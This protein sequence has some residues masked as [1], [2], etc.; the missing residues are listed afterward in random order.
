MP[1][2][3][4]CNVILVEDGI[5]FESQDSHPKA[6]FTL[7]ND[8]KLF[9]HRKSRKI[10]V[11][12]D[13]IVQNQ[14]SFYTRK[15]HIKIHKNGN[16]DFEIPQNTLGLEVNI[17]IKTEK[18]CCNKLVEF[19]PENCRNDFLATRTE[20]RMMFKHCN[21]MAIDTSGLDHTPVKPG[22]NRVFGHQL[23]PCR[24]AR[25][26]AIVHIA[27][28]EAI[29][30]I[31]GGYQSLLNLPPVSSSA[32]V[33]AAMCQA[34]HDTLVPLF[35]SH[36]PRLDSI[37]AAD[38]AQIPN[39]SS[40]SNGINAG[41]AAASAILANRT[42]DGSNHAEPVYGVDYIPSGAPGEWEQD[43]ISQI[44]VALGALWSQVTPFVIPSA[45]AYRCPVPPA[46]NSVEYMMAFNDA[47]AMGG[48]G[49]TTPTIRSDQ[50][51]QMGIFWAYDGTPSLCAPPRLYNQLCMQI[52][53]DNGLDT[54]ELMY[55][56]T[57]L[58]VGMADVG[59]AS[60]ES[61]YFYKLWRPVTGIRRAAE[62]GNPG[63]IADP[64]WTPMGAPASNKNTV[65]FTPPFPTYPSGHAS[66]GGCVF[67]L[68]RKFLPDNTSF[69]FVSDELNGETKDNQGN[70][71]PLI[72]RS[73]TSFSQAEEENGK[74]RIP[75]GIH[76]NQ[77]KTSGIIIGNQIADYVF[78]NLYQPN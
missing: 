29:I 43:P 71:R 53:S 62:N 5:D 37:L 75:L 39:G 48:D 46:L 51:T 33:E 13:A 24:A 21:Q 72:P 27:M 74:S 14:M 55:M 2:T 18:N 20:T 19:Y 1:K 68:L 44:P 31:V 4:C 32:S 11:K 26:M 7:E 58:N 36:Q 34:L 73:F 40:K 23:G 45:D 52:G 9:K 42:N 35:P 12:Y 28:F 78:D 17:F 3:E 65:N 41:A 70:S 47:K 76:W 8:C 77:D 16:F 30:S 67:G 38:L 56:I 60:W 61:K 10:I 22:E 64:T 25:A 6:R 54:M 57:L 63:T 15:L 66:F 50:E 49:I 59:I 69:T